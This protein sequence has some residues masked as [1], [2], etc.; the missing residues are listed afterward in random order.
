M[1]QLIALPDSG[2]PWNASERGMLEQIQRAFR[3]ERPETQCKYGVTDAGDPWTAFHDAANGSPVAKI[4]RIGAFYFLIWADE[5]FVRA[6]S[7][8]R[9]LDAVRHGRAHAA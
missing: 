5:T 3:E 6:T 2:R 7:L 4:A 1:P 8:S 9:F